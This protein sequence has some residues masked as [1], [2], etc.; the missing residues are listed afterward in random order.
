MVLARTFLGFDF[1]TQQIKVIA[2]KDDLSISYE[3]FVQFDSDLPEFKT[4]G[5]VH[6]HTD[7]LTVTAPTL[8]WVKALDLLLNK[9][10]NDGFDFATVSALSGTGQQHGSVFWK[11]GSQK[12][13][14][15]AKPEATLA[16][17]LSD[18]FSVKDSPIWMDSSTTSICR[19]LE[20]AVGGPQK[21]ADITGSRAYERF[22]ASQIAKL[23]RSNPDAYRNTER[24]SL[25]SSFAASL[26]LGDYAAIDNS[27]GSGMNLLDIR[28][29]QWSKDCLNFTA[30]DL[31]KKLDNTL[32]SSS[33]LGTVSSYLV[34]KYGFSPACQVIAFTGD[35]PA[36]L[37]GCRLKRGDVVVSLGTSDT[38][39][40]WLDDPKPSTEGHVFVNPVDDDAYMGLL[41]YKN[42]S[43]TRERI[44]DSAAGG[45]WDN[46]S[47]ALKNTPL[48]N[49]GNVGIYFDVQEITPSAVGTFRFNSKNE[50]VTSFTDEEEVRALVEG[51]FL[52]KRCHAER[53]GYALG[54]NSRVLATGGA[55]SNKEILQ[56]LSDVF[57]T[58]VYTLDTSN[59]TCLGCAFRAKHGFLGG[60]SILFE[61][62]VASAAPY[63]LACTPTPFSCDTERY[64]RLE[65]LVS[66]GSAFC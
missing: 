57:Q 54:K 23:T 66:G 43:I 15:N 32:P 63:K 9:M 42:G 10:K 53:L 7:R 2:V 30:E 6:I 35:N 47:F 17:Q 4:E 27:D 40:L 41:C 50:K 37:A 12:L 20:E 21:L 11:C 55:S 29:K 19:K 14:Q 28:S 25:V 1:S 56:V 58:P 34:K 48:G 60:K 18:A 16:E 45:N 62:V 26:F 13:L 5:G 3:T 51:Q 64:M 59:S 8:M 52:A 33:V 39:M 22:T 46:F 38:F 36:S 61:E 24:I 44:R 49:N 31:C 65:A